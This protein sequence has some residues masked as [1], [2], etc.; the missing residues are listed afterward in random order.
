MCFILVIKVHFFEKEQESLENQLN[1]KQGKPQFPRFV[2]VLSLI[3]V[4]FD[5]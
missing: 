4:S 5:V 2:T 3:A 1:R